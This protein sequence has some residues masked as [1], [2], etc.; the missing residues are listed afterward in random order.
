[1][2]CYGDDT[3]LTFHDTLLFSLI[4]L[5]HVSKFNVHDTPIT[6][7]LRLTLVSN[8]VIIRLIKFVSRF[9]IHLCNVIYFST[10][11]NTPYTQFTKIIDFGILDLNTA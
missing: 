8:H 1:M 2:E 5:V 3:S 10:I 11:F 6:L 7:P 4:L 9:T